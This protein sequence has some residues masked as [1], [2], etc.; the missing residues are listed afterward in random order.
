MTQ[1][2]PGTR[3]EWGS[4]EPAE[5]GLAVDALRCVAGYRLLF[6][7][8]SFQLPPGRWLRLT[9]PNGA[10]KSTLLRALAGLGR[11]AAGEIRWNGALREPGSAEWHSVMLYQG[12]S[13]GW[14]DTF[15][16]RDNL[17]LQRAL[18]S[19]LQPGDGWS[20]IDELLERC[21]LQ[22][23]TSLSFARLSAG[24]RHRLSLARLAG[25]KRSLWLL[26]EPTTALDS[27]GQALFG[28]L[29]SE[30]LARGGCAVIATHLPIAC[31]QVAV[32]LDLGTRS[33][34]A[35]SGQH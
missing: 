31:D 16:A 29:L 19:G 18:D 3:S 10:G 5:S 4:P 13:A 35:P 9:G 34:T 21:G 26:D 17:A 24:Q 28:R 2:S 8:L 1:A 7:S 25:A 20:E 23:R 14:K 32:E 27:A 33:G 15:S 30:H 12:H 22:S 11:P 6:D